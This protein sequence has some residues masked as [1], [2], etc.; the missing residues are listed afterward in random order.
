MMSLGVNA[1]SH[2]GSRYGVSIKTSLQSVPTGQTDSPRAHD[3]PRVG[4]F[5]FASH[6]YL[7][8]K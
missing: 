4:S 5:Y 1:E 2:M 7:A 3:A 8:H 6:N